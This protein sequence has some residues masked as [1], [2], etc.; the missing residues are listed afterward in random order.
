VIHYPLV[1]NSSPLFQA[2]LVLLSRLFMNESSRVKYSRI[3]TVFDCSSAGGIIQIGPWLSF[4]GVSLAVS[5]SA[6]PLKFCKK[7]SREKEHLRLILI[8]GIPEV[9]TLE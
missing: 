4:M 2:S 5:Q 8:S 7:R 6:F 3:K 9:K 1:E